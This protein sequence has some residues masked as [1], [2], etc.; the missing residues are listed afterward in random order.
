MNCKAFTSFMTKK[1]LNLL[2]ALA[3][4]LL[5]YIVAIGFLT[6]SQSWLMSFVVLM[7]MLWTNDALPL[8]VVSLLPVVIFPAAGVLDTKEVALNY[9]NP[10]IFLF[11]GGFMLAIAVE[12]TALHKWIAVQLLNL[13]PLT[14]RGVI[15]ALIMT[16]GLLSSVLSNTTTALLLLPIALF[17]TEDPA[18]KS[19]LMLAV[20]YGASVGG[21]LTPIGTPPNLI[22]MGLAQEW[23]LPSPGFVQWVAM[24]AP[25]VLS[26]FVI[27][28]FVLSAGLKES[29]FEVD[30]SVQALSVPQKKVLSLL[31]LLVVVLFINAPFEPYHDGLGLSEAGLL[32]AA[33]LLLFAPPFSILEWKA[34]K[35]KIPL[36]IIFLFGAGFAIAAAFIET[37]MAKILAG[38]L[39]Q[40]AGAPLIMFMLIVA[41]IVT[42]TTEVTSNTA[43][44][45]IMLPV[46]YEVSNNAGLNVTLIMMLATVCASYAFMLPI[47]T[48]PNA[49]AMS[50]GHVSVKT[51]AGYGFIM[52]LLAIFLV[53]VIARLYWFNVL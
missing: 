28:G 12:K 4:A 34:D 40:F 10:I 36:Q 42:F 19:R 6:P 35:D 26:M 45:S 24:M 27:A 53:V 23:G 3:L 33:G 46:L 1:H 18:I 31:L 29:R 30:L 52:N 22:F 37:G 17:L 38:Q 9:A 15:L 49:I 8:A 41:L 11:L 43:L 14:T 16:A 51:M 48:P 50:S 32:L 25:L 20:A 5:V 44:I 21:I 47:A 13:F 7:V 2:V 39:T